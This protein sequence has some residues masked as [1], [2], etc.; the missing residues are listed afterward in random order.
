MLNG[1]LALHDVR[2]VEAFCATIIHRSRLE[3]DEHQHEDL[4]AYLVETA[5]QL[6]TADPQPWR[7]SFSGYATPLLRLRIIDWQRKRHGRTRWQFA[8]YTRTRTRPTLV[9]LDDPQH[10]GL[11]QPR[12]RHALD[13]ADDRSPDLL[14]VLT[15]GGSTRTSPAGALGRGPARATR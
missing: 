9:S 8:G 10:G 12:T 7:T 15:Q 2:D 11:E 5:W 4:L 14:R 6:S 1:I 3:L 13:P